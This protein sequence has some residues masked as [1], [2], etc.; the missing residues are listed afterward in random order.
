MA[1]KT[2]AKFRGT[3][4]LCWVCQNC[5][6]D[7]SWS[8]E[9]IPVEGW[10]ARATTV[11]R[12]YRGNPESYL[13]LSCPEFIPEAH[14]CN[15]CANKRGCTFSPLRAGKSRFVADC[16]KFAPDAP[17]FPHLDLKKLDAF[18]KKEEVQKQRGGRRKRAVQQ[19]SADRSTYIR[20]FES[21]SAAAREVGGTNTHIARVCDGAWKSAKGY[22]WRWIYSE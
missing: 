4:T 6:G 20:D 7:C 12:Q 2:P 17:E 9:Y 15:R 3:V 21:L 14:L 22:W 8:R 19:W 16:A 13:V 1:R 18:D 5:F 11:Q 10:K